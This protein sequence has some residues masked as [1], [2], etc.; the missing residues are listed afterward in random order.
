[1]GNTNTT[2][3]DIEIF[4]NAVKPFIKDIKRVCRVRPDT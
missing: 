1:M 4:F 2:E 3:S